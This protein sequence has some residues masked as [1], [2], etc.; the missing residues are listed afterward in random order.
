MTSWRTF[1]MKTLYIPTS[2][3]NFN[4]ILSS[5]SVSPK[6]FYEKRNFGYSRWESIPENP[7]KNVIL[8][9]DNLFSFERPKSD[10]EDHPMLI[11]VQ[12][13][14]NELKTF[15]DGI[16]YVD[17]TIYLSPNRTYFIFF[18]EEDKKITLSLSQSSLETKLLPLYY[19]RMKIERPSGNYKTIGT[20]LQEPSTLN[21]LEIFNDFRLNKLK[22]LLYGYYIGTT[23]SANI[24]D[25]RKLNT[26][27]EIHNIFAAIISSFNKKPTNIQKET[28]DTLFEKLNEDNPLTKGLFEIVESKTSV[29][30]I[31]DLIE[32]TLGHNPRLDNHEFLH[33][34]ATQSSGSD[35]DNDAIRWIKDEIKKCQHEIEVKR[36]LLSPEKEEIIISSDK[37]TSLKSNLLEDRNELILT[38]E[39][40]NEILSNP[41]YSGK[42]SVHKES[43]AKDI[44]L[45][46][47]EVIGDNWENSI[48]KRH[49][50]KLRHFIA[51]EP[52]ELD[53]NND[54]LSS[55]SA[56]LI[57]GDRWDTLLS[58]MQCKEMTNYS[59]V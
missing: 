33:L 16:F 59:I 46:A 15:S 32:K 11:E 42:V 37:L 49:L 8:L 38:Q 52:T 7:F 47:K 31:L 54:L 20:P 45:K 27:K 43:L 53:W 12:I 18:T 13:G 34:L 17:K 29:S 19:Q 5:E 22:G 26:L 36:Q 30:R 6:S 14:E 3:L 58:S 28:L 40:V 55:I 48:Y 1:N 44:T 10:M 57:Y 21:E 2:S 35:K 25:V 56:V 4:N 23:L 51:N 24:D 9:Y 50:N 41:D 39:W